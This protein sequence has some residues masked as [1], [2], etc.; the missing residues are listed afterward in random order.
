[1]SPFHLVQDPG[2]QQ[3]H[4]P[5]LGQPRGSAGGT[6]HLQSHSEH[7]PG[8]GLVVALVRLGKYIQDL[9]IV[10]A[11]VGVQD[12]QGRGLGQSELG[13]R[14]VVGSEGFLPKEASKWD[15]RGSSGETGQ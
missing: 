2:W 5:H 13:Q 6:Y 1:M 9:Q 10:A 4:P 11:Q 7:L 12:Q 14:W 15:R 3:G 8:D